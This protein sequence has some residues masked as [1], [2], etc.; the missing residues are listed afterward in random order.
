MSLPP[1]LWAHVDAQAGDTRSA[2]LAVVV[3]QEAAVPVEAI[4]RV[5]RWIEDEWGE[6]EPA[7]IVGEWLDKWE[8]K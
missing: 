8:V 1:A 7:T 5:V 4:S 2:R 6:T 3:G